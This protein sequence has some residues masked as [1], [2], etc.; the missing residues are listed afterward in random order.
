MQTPRYRRRPIASLS[1]LSK[2]LDVNERCLSFILRDVNR[3]YFPAKPCFK[4]DGT[5]REIFRVGGPLKFVQQRIK[6]RIF[7]QVEFPSYLKGGIKGGSPIRNAKIHSGATI[8]I[9][10]DV[11]NFFP[12]ITVIVVKKMWMHFFKLPEEIAETLTILTTF[13]GC[14][15]QGACTSTYLANL[16]LWDKEPQLKCRLKERGLE[17]TRY[18]DDINVSS[19]RRLSEEG[20]IWVKEKIRAMFSTKG[21]SVNEKKSVVLRQHERM[22]AH[23]LTIN[24]AAPTLSRLTQRSLKSE[25]DEIEKSPS[26]QSTD[27]EGK[28][29]SLKGK[30]GYWNQIQPQ[31]AARQIK[32]HDKIIGQFSNKK[33]PTIQTKS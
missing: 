13:R 14:V 1:S 20:V 19:K 5:L 28:L 9:R 8:I 33:P 18:V 29:K 24:G 17:Y 30:L 22:T 3:F 31:K 12:S 27:K 16:I 10:E 32:R 7:R 4:S 25:L 23:N 26:E 21:L 11:R 6:R 2:L 15:P